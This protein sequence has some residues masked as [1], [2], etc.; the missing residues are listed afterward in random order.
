VDAAALPDDYIA[1]L[2]AGADAE[3]LN[4]SSTGVLLESTTRLLPGRRYTLR[5]GPT[6]AA[7]VIDGEVARCSLTRVTPAGQ[8]VYRA[9]IRFVSPLDALPPE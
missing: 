7:R 3:V 6:A 8:A 4:V 5:I 9:A 2:R 1:R